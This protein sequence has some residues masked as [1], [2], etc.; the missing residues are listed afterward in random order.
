M[1]RR[2]GS[3][4]H[5]TRK[6]TDVSSENG[7]AGRGRCRTEPTRR[8]GPRRPPG[9]PPAP[10]R[11]AGPCLDAA[12]RLFAERGIDGVTLRDI[13]ERPTC[14][15]ADREVC[16][17]PGRAEEAG[18]RGPVDGARG[19]S[20]R[21]PA[22][23]SGLHARNGDVDMGPCGECLVI[24]GRSLV[25]LAEFNPVKAMA[26]TLQDAYGCDPAAA[27][28][29]SAQIVAVALGWRIFEEY[30]IERGAFDDIPI[31]SLRIELT[32]SARRLGA[33]PWPSPPDP[34]VSE[35]PSPRHGRARRPDRTPV[36]PRTGRSDRRDPRAATLGPR[37]GHAPDL[38]ARPGSDPTWSPEWSWLRSWSHRAWPTRSSPDSRR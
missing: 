25:G 18:L 13:A 15:R 35:G 38:R 12:A 19:C 9:A 22:C 14:T 10:T 26:A 36:G 3:A 20:R 31:E 24:S 34:E 33:T 17:Y 23:G 4:A 27:R 6:S 8:R 2:H 29:R 7:G 5:R 16:R 21:D 30:L 28:L 37:P 1:D 32:R 11:S